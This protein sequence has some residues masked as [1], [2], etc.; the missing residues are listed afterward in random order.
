MVGLG[1]LAPVSQCWGC[2]A[3]KKRPMGRRG[4]QK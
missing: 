3:Q 1:M 4:R 2:G